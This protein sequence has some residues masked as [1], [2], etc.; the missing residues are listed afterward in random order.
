MGTPGFVN[1]HRVT[2]VGGGLSFG[3][4][5]GR[6]SVASIRP[7]SIHAVGSVGR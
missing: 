2:F 7:A 3:E 5:L 4:M 6:N 1:G